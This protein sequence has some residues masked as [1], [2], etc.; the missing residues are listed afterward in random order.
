MMM[1]DG[2]HLSTFGLLTCGKS[3]IT[4][5]YHH[6][7]YRG[8]NL[9]ETGSI[10]DLGESGKSA[11]DRSADLRRYSDGNRHRTAAGGSTTSQR[12]RTCT[13]G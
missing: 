1:A 7:W 5:P 2:T 9:V 11:L 6:T 3:Q 12:A 13:A 8:V 4:L 10:I